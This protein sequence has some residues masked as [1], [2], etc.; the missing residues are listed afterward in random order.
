MGNWVAPRLGRIVPLA[1]TAGACLAV[2]ALAPALSAAAGN[3]YYA[4]PGGASSGA[5]SQAQRCSIDFAVGKTSDGD[6]VSLTAGEY[7][8][9]FGGLTVEKRIDLGAQPGASATIETTD[10][11]DIHVVPKAH[12]TLHDMRI[13]GEGGLRLNSGTG[14]RLF[15]AF[16]GTAT[17]ACTLEEGTVLRDSVCWARE[18]PS[19]P[20]EV[21]HA[22]G[23]EAS[24]EKLDE[25]VVLRNV[26]AIAANSS[27]DAIHALG[28]FGAKLNVDARNV[29]ARSANHTDVVAEIQGPGGLPKSH[30]T[31]TN[32][33]FATI[34]QAP[35]PAE[36]TAPGTNGNQT[37]P[38]VFADAAAGDFH[39]AESSP[40]LDAGATDLAVGTRDPDGNARALSKCFGTDAVP[41]IGA[42]ERRATAECPPPPPPLPPSVEPPKPTFRIVRLTLNKH[43]GRGSLRV[44][45]PAPGTLALAGSGVKLVRRTAGAAGDVITMPIQPWAIT[46]VRLAKTGKSRVKLK[47]IFEP[48]IGPPA[49]RAMGILL[50]RNSK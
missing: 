25:P 32:S 11:A 6:S 16:S 41:D 9:P 13:E 23:I 14:E 50:R 26:D 37:A 22:V 2:S 10:T 44:E 27:G 8:L 35:E 4:S 42:Y 3:T 40:T 38:P 28:A 30:V 48:R 46:L 29:I 1:L 18:A 7:T 43:T 17:N 5:C 31:I 36:V 47:L 19:N 15:V 45:V 33:N 34:A 12:A 24:G 21:A 49:L 39:E 20:G